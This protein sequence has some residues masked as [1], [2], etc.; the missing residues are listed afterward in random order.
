MKGEYDVSALCF[1][2]VGYSVRW[3]SKT[4]PMSSLSPP[5]R[6]VKSRGA[7]LAAFSPDG[8]LLSIVLNQRDP[9][10]S[11]SADDIYIYIVLAVHCHLADALIQSDLQ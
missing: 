3:A 4:Y 10:V 1:S 9:R 2:S 5:C 7:L 11:G 8:Q 6:P